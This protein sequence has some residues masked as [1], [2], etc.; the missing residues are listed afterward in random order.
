MFMIHD[1]RPQKDWLNTCAV[2]SALVPA[3]RLMPH[4]CGWEEELGG[5]LGFVSVW[6]QSA[7][8]WDNEGN[9]KRITNIEQGISNAEGKTSSFEIRCSIFDIPC[10]SMACL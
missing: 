7:M 2:V 10:G 3:R 5:I 6:P 4:S 1:Y 8:G 9:K